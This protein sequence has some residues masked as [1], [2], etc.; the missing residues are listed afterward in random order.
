MKPAVF[1]L[2]DIFDSTRKLG[3][4]VREAGA[5]AGRISRA[6]NRGVDL[7]GDWPFGPNNGTLVKQLVPSITHGHG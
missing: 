1:G 4:A 2:L 5:C 6:V 3:D 7:L